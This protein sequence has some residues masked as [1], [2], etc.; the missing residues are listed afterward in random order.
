MKILLNS[1]SNSVQEKTSFAGAH[2]FSR[3]F[4]EYFSK[5]GHTFTAVS[6]IKPKGK[7]KGNFSVSPTWKGK[8]KWLIFQTKV[9][10]DEIMTLLKP[11]PPAKIMN[12]VQ[13]LAE[14][15]KKEKADLFLLNG[16]SAMM[17]LIMRA[18]KLAGI[19]V[20]AIHHGLWFKENEAIIK[21]LGKSNFEKRK[22]LEKEIGKH[23]AKNIFLNEY[24]VNEYQKVLGK[25]K[26]SQIKIIPLPYNPIFLNK[27]LPPPNNS[28]IKRIGL[29]A[30]W[31]RIKNHDGFLSLAYEA[32]RQNL[33]WEFYAITKI[34]KYEPYS[35]MAEDYKK[36]IKIVTQIT[37]IKLKKFY[38]RMD[39]V[40][41]PSRFETYSAVAMEALLQNRPVIV[42]QQVPWAEIFEKNGL[43]SWVADFENPAKT[44]KILG[45]ALKQTPPKSLLKKIT[46]I[47]NPSHIYGEYI[48]TLLSVTK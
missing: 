21:Q 25:I 16:F 37:P 14:E 9:T 28:P 45:S 48:K 47:N 19:P 22:L 11:N 1:N 30:R 41:V 12:I 38:Q 27:K 42:S 7:L 2:I 20:V 3:D 8:N 33:P 17:C 26:S 6:F 23:S 5:T 10:S 40:V 44:V 46:I 29:V 18:A 15:M 34:Q 43:K 32:K 24:T 36:T 13:R 4:L 31:D 39:L 35:L